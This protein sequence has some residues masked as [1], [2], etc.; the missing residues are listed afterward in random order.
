MNTMWERL[1]VALGEPGT[2][3]GVVWVLTAV[4][5]KI[6]P[7]QAQAIATVGM[8]VAGLIGVFFKDN[9]EQ[10]VVEQQPEVK[11]APTKKENLS[12]VVKKGR[13]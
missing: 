4:G 2:W 7:E 9:I 3:K 1:G 11:P 13:K 8:A 12:D 6:D 5:L 10:P